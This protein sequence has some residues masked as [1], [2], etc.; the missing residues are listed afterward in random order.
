[1]TRLRDAKG[2]H[3][4]A[5]L[6]RHPDTEFHVLDVIAAVGAVGATS[7]SVEGPSDLGDAGE[8]LDA[9]A[10]ATYRRRLADVREEIEEARARH[11]LGWI[12]RLQSEMDFLSR[13]LAG[14][15]GLDG[16]VRRAGSAAERARINVTRRIGWA[17]RRIA[18]ADPSLGRYLATTIRTGTF[19]SYMRDPR[20]PVRWNL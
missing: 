5:H 16:R 6:L 12:D 8:V 13:E 11:D 20:I 7:T 3:Y 14:G 2:L 17:V 9:K 4:I 1:V 10:R 18:Q 15:I 19:C